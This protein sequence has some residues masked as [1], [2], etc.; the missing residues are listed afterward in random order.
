MVVACALYMPWWEGHDPTSKDLCDQ[1][2]HA[3]IGKL[4]PMAEKLKVHLN[5]ENIFFNAYHDADGDE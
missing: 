2:A 5:I 3:A 4:L 1:R